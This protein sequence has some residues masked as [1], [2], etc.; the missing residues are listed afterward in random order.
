LAFT[1]LYDA[2]VLYPA[3]LRD[4]LLMV[5]QTGL[6]RAR[7]TEQI[8]DEWIGSLVEKRPELVEL[9]KV[10]RQKMNDAVLDCVVTGHESLIEALQLPDKGD[11]HVL[12]AAIVGRAHVIVTYNL[13]DFPEEALKP[14]GIQAEHPD[15]FISNLFDLAPAKVTAQVKAIRARLQN[16]P[17]T[18]DELLDTYLSLGL[19]E[20]VSDLKTMREL[21]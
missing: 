14:Y 10:T 17:R 11:R 1:A 4:L 20:T 16:P 13:K 21:L 9:L 12:A 19:P 15:Q 5:A 7:W 3:P 18:I 8:H 6:F 2:C